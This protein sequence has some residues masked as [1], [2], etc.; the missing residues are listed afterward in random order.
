MIDTCDP[1]LKRLRQK[2]CCTCLEPAWTETLFER[3]NKKQV[4]NNNNK[5]LRQVCLVQRP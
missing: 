2:D 5:A 1:E 3:N 4:N